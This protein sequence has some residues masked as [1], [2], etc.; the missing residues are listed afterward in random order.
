MLIR[1]N[2]MRWLT[3]LSNIGRNNRSLFRNKRNNRGAVLFSLLGLG[4]GAIATYG[5]TRGQGNKI[6]SS[7][8][9]PIL[10]RFK[11]NKTQD[12]LPEQ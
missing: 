11:N 3:S 9:Q 1:M 6:I 8:V 2:N 10:N 7:T 5:M 4:I 12:V